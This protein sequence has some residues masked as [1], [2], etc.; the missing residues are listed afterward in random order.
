MKKEDQLLKKYMEKG[1]LEKWFPGIVEAA[2]KAV[3]DEAD[4]RG[5][6]IGVETS[7]VG[8]GTGGDG[9]K[10]G[11]DGGARGKGKGMGVKLVM[12]G[13]MPDGDG[14]VSMS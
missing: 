1:R 13:R 11:G 8:T 14:D 9:G 7:E 3:R 6:E 5:V 12:H 10:E 4:E 2:R